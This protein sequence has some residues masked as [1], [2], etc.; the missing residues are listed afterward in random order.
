MKKIIS[1]I[2]FLCIG[3]SY[4]MGKGGTIPTPSSPC[5]EQLSNLLLNNFAMYGNS[6]VGFQRWHNLNEAIDAG[7]TITV[8]VKT[9]GTDCTYAGST[10]TITATSLYKYDVIGN[11]IVNVSTPKNTEWDATIKIESACVYDYYLGMHVKY[12]WTKTLRSST[13]TASFDMQF[14][15]ASMCPSSNQNVK[16]FIEREKKLNLLQ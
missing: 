15:L 2:V 13:Q 7:Y 11:T 10:K 4:S 14:G 12:T 1:T 6:T 9:T 5:G 8:T 16:S 3:I